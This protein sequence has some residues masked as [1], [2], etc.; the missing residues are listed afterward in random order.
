VGAN[1]R[2]RAGALAALAQGELCAKALSALLLLLLEWLGHL[3]AQAPHLGASTAQ[4]VVKTRRKQQKKQRTRRKRNTDTHKT[5]IS[6]CPNPP[7]TRYYQTV[8][9]PLGQGPPGGQE[10]SHCVVVNNQ[11]ENQLLAFKGW[12]MLLDP[13]GMAPMVLSEPWGIPH[14]H[15]KLC[16]MLKCS[17]KTALTSLEA[18]CSQGDF[19]CLGPTHMLLKTISYLIS[20]PL[21]TIAHPHP[22]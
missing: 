19:H 16:S 1:S 18:C 13:R 5:K 22:H 21:L 10:G 12:A 8:G 15:H 3:T 6:C 11:T 17:I 20:V 14:A 9:Q 2:S 4:G 7:G